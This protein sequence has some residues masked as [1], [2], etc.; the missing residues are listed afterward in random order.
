[1]PEISDSSRRDNLDV[2]S[3]CWPCREA[4]FQPMV[5]TPLV[6]NRG[7]GWTPIEHL[8]IVSNL[9]GENFI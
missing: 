5:T 6:P 8:A 3:F 9:E 1:M 4:G 2:L 7:I